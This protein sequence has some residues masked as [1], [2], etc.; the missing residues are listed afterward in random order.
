MSVFQ[1]LLLKLTIAPIH[2]NNRVRKFKTD[3]LPYLLWFLVLPLL[4]CGKK[5][6]NKNKN[7]NNNNII[8]IVGVNWLTSFINSSNID[9]K[10]NSQYFFYLFIL[11]VHFFSSRLI[12]LLLF[13][14]YIDWV[15]KTT[16]NIRGLWFDK[17]LL[18]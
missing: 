5:K 13:C 12:F 7:K 1:G 8:V 9:I 3:F 4:S 14:F 18:W 17:K 2:V 16:S 11:F 15:N 6:N 10:I